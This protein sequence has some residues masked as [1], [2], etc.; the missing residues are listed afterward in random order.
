MEETNMIKKRRSKRNVAIILTSVLSIAMASTVMA[1]PGGPGGNAGPSGN[2]G[3]GGRAGL[4]GGFE[5]RGQMPSF[6]EGERPELPTF[7]EGERPELPTFE[8]GERPEPPEFDGSDRPEPPEGQMTETEDEDRTEPSE[9]EMPKRR[10]MKDGRE[11]KGIDTDSI[12]TAIED[13]DDE[14][15]KADLETLLAEYTEAKSALDS[16][17]ES[18]SEDIDTYRK[19]EMD[20]MKALRE[21]LDE[22]GIDT[23]PELPEGEDGERPEFDNDLGQTGR[24]IIREDLNGM[25]QNDQIPSNSEKSELI[26]RNK[27]GSES[28]SDTT[29]NKFVKWLESLFS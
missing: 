23:R 27:T 28:S 5:Q 3:P 15:V 16:A 10:E 11:M 14:D 13:L 20:A 19:A 18:E 25:R 29:F 2:G 22:A 21:A 24:Q 4:Q 7:E 8:E 9:G 6:E 17:I 26:N 12:Q 1:A